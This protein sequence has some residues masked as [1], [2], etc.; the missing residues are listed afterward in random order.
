MQRSPATVRAVNSRADQ[1]SMALPALLLHGETASCRVQ[2][3]SYQPH[4][5]QL[6][7][8]NQRQL[9]TVV[10]LQHWSATLRELGYHTVRTTAL[11]SM[12]ALR[13]EAAGFRCLQELVLLEHTHPERAV[14]R[15]L[16][17]HV[18]RSRPTR[19]LTHD[20]LGQASAVDLAAFGSD[21]ALDTTAIAAVRAATPRHRVR[22]VGEPLSGF[23]ISGRD[24]R[25]GFLQRLAVEPSEHRSGIGSA[26]V[27]D[28]L[29][30]LARWRVQRVLVNTPVDNEPAVALYQKLGFR[31]LGERLRVYELA[32]K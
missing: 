22:G 1:S 25:Q 32:L 16:G 15:P 6:V 28:S 17:P 31:R 20:D 3:W 14:L 4:V 10:D 30:W 11:A 13:A 27:V 8:Y 9:P 2:H 21:W 12:A 24:G 5:A 7:L 29:R 18:R 26:L 19:R 23:A